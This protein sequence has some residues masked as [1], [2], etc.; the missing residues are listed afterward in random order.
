[1]CGGVDG[2]DGCEERIASQVAALSRR[3][4]AATYN[5]MKRMVSIMEQESPEGRK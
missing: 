4:N 1:M 3:Q 2:G 5:R